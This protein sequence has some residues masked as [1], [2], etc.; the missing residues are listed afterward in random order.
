M[1][2]C[3]APAAGVRSRTVTCISVPRSTVC[4]TWVTDGL[5]GELFQLTGRFLPP[6]PPGA[7]VPPQW[8]DEVHIDELFAAAGAT[9]AITRK[10]VEFEYPSVPALVESYSN[11]FGVFVVARRILEPQGRWEEFVDAFTELV[12]R[13]NLAGD[14][15]AR[16]A[17]D[18][19]L[20]LASH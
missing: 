1:N 18:Y 19:L 17:S 11:E 3:V 8:G 6:P 13:F 4:A 14:G 15:T 10:T 9:V 12:V 7:G 2:R 20:I 16:I 5:A